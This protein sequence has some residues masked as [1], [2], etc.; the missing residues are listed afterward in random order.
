MSVEAASRSRAIG[1]MRRGACDGLRP[2]SVVGSGLDLP[3]RYGVK[4]R[5]LVWSGLLH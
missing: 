2:R 3:A 5:V 4:I 1:A